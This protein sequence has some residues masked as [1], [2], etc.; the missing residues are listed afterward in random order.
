MQPPE[1][2]KCCPPFQGVYYVEGVY[3][4]VYL[5]IRGTPEGQKCGYA[6]EHWNES[7]DEDSPARLRE[8]EALLRELE[9]EITQKL[10]ESA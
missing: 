7:M 6:K 1:L 2:L 9:E 3:V 8:Y 4:G 5:G 10:N